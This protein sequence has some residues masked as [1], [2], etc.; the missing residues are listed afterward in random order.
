MYV[1]F[2]GRGDQAGSDVFKS[3]D[4]VLYADFPFKVGS[5]LS[6]FHHLLYD[7]FVLVV[8]HVGYRDVFH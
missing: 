2:L 4:N 3:Y 7:I 8:R 5:E 6:F 1:T